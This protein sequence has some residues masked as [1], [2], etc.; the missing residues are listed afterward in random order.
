M[1]PVAVHAQP[2][3]SARPG[4]TTALRIEHSAWRLPD[5]VPNAIVHRP[6][7]FDASRP[8][9]IVILLHG[10][11]T[12]INVLVRSGS[13]ACAP[14][15]RPEAGW[16]VADRF[17]A[18]RPNALLVVPQ[19]AYRTQVGHP[20]RFNR[21]GYGRAVVDEAL[22]A[23]RDEVD[24]ASVDGSA[25]VLVVAHSAGF[26]SAFALSRRGGFGAKLRR[27]ALMDALYDI[28]EF[29]GRW[30]RDDASRSLVSLATG[31][32]TEQNGSRLR[33]YARRSM[34]ATSVVFNPDEARIA[35]S[36]R[37]HRVVVAHIDSEHSE[38]LLRYLDDVI[39]P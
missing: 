28:P 19:L 3:S 10:W 35:E 18:A 26:E 30:A 34:G 4:A 15:G 27:I 2:P 9:D 31:G 6:P 16:G 7:S 14:G 1:A 33:D 8:Y 24:G 21:E 39:G 13:V 29:F 32:R 12:C 25:R 23:V 22:A 20:G 11:S 37:T 17:D 36:I 38:A 5:D